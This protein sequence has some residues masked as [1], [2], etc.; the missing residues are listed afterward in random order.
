MVRSGLC[1]IWCGSK[2]SIWH[3]VSLEVVYLAYGVV[4]SGLCGIWCG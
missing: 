1:G 3:M 4:R 2:W